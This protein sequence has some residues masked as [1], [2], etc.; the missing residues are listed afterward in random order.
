MSKDSHKAEE[1][2]LADG[3]LT[4]E[5]AVEFSGLPRTELFRLMSVGELTSFRYGNKTKL[6]PKRALV[7][8]LARRYAADQAARNSA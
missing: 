6:I 5:A 4:V 7:A 8:Y 3:A 2:L 1:V